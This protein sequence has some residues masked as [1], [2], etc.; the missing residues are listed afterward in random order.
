MAA[1][2]SSSVGRLM[3]P[4]LPTVTRTALLAFVCTAALELA[5]IIAAGHAPW[6]GKTVFFPLLFLLD[7]AVTWLVIG[8]LQAVVGS[9]PVTAALSAMTTALVAVVDHEKVRVLREPLYPGDLEF[10][11]EAGFMADMVG[12]HLV[13]LLL[14]VA[15]LAAVI[16]VAASQAARRWAWRRVRRPGPRWQS[17]IA[18]LVAGTLC[19]AGLNYL[20]DFN[21]PRNAARGA[22]ELFGAEWTS[23]NPEVNYL[24]HGFVGGYLYNLEVPMPAPDGYSRDELDRISQRYGAIDR[25]TNRT[26]D[27]HALDDVNVVLVLSESFSDPLA[28]EG[29]HV[30]E[31]PI[32]FVRSMMTSA[33]GGNMLSQSLGGRTANMEFEA[34]TGMSVSQFPEQARVPYHAIV[35]DY[36]TFPSVA[37]SMKHRG[38]RAVAIHPNIPQLYRRRDVYRIFGFDEFVDDSRMHVDYRIGHDA[39]ISDAAAFDELMIT[40]KREERPVLV[41]LVTMQNHMPYDGRYDDPINVT[42]PD[43]EPLEN[44]G[45]YVRGLSHSDAAV[46]RLI[47]QLSRS[48]ERTVLVYYGDHLP[49]VYPQSVLQRNTWRTRHQTPFFVWANFPGPARPMPTTSPVN[50]LWLALERANAPVTPYDA[51]LQTLWREVPAMDAGLIIDAEDRQVPASALSTRALRVLR[52]Y[53]LVQYDLSVGERYTEATMFAVP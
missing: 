34:L 18:R 51:L 3:A 46:E 15:V 7:V 40:L 30:D 23:S 27:P 53:R 31:D 25:R 33:T 50:F 10:V 9:F 43:G 32:P 5:R 2:L 36:A 13:P 44:V 38:H 19:L 6:F 42:G 48:D 8:L 24:R 21:A 11:Q 12:P 4:F 29:L 16:V 22:F 41:N 45:Q 14:L 20:S 26:R 39:W 52:D 49:G 17:V 47:D 35:P 28:L 1:P 37:A